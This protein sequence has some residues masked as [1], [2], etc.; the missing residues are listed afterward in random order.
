[1]RRLPRRRRQPS[2]YLTTRLSREY[3]YRETGFAI[4]RIAVA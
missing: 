4:D 2:R 1:V 3:G